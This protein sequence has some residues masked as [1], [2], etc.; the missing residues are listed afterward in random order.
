M[1]DEMKIKTKVIGVDI[2]L[3]YTTCAVIDIRG[4]ILGKDSFAMTDYPDVNNFVTVLCEKIVKLA[5]AHGGFENIRSVGV[6]APSS[7][8]KTGC[9]E[10]AS[11]LKWKGVVPLAAML[12][13]RLGIAV[14]VGNDAHVAALAERT[15]GSAH[16]MDNFLVMTFTDGGVGSSIF[17]NGRVH[18]GTNGF[19]GEIGHTLVVENGRQCGC[20]HK[21]CLE[22]YVSILG[23]VQNLRDLLEES[24][25]PSL[26]R[27][28][29]NLNAQSL[30]LCCQQGDKLALEAVNRAGRIL[31]RAVANY[32]SA[33]NPEA[34]ILSGDIL[35]VIDWMY[36]VLRQ[37]LDENVFHNLRGKVRLL[38]SLLEPDERTVLGAGALAWEVPEYS[39]FK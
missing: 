24:D 4:Y 18:L 5:E 12:R 23:I 32:S 35:K 31:G 13:D 21:G 39:L 22:T 17:V 25:E 15:Y 10:N 8:F 30:V 20:G 2:T 11:N 16:G 9:V 14:A 28:I 7:N 29:E 36:P 33:I 19:S 37:T 26:A 1:R 34:I 27:N 3:N 6:S 38:A